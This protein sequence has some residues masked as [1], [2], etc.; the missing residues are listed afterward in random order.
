MQNVITREISIN[1]SQ[2]RVYAAISQ[3]EQVVKWFPETL[4]G[5]YSVG[6]QPVFGFGEHAKSQIYVAEARPHSYFAYRWVPGANH[7]LGDVLSVANTLVE[8]MI[9][10]VDSHSC[11][12]TLTETGFAHLPQEAMEASF[13]QNSAGWDFMLGRL[14]KQF[15]QEPAS[16]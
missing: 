2:A 11:K 6:Q 4:E 16:A 5:D 3:P 15:T 8:F 14:G 12:V 7:F 1:A 13:Q 9:E 10:A